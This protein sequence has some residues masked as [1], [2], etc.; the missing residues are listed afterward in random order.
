MHALKVFA[1]AVG[2]IAYCVAT[3]A[4]LALPGFLIAWLLFDASPLD[5]IWFGSKKRHRKRMKETH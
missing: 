2:F 5:A 3:R 1:L 4:V